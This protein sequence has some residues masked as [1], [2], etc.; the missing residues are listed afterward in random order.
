[1]NFNN[2]DNRIKITERGNEFKAIL[3]IPFFITN[4]ISFTIMEFPD[5]IIKHVCVYVCVNIMDVLE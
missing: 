1:M 4:N 5:N 3:I 2:H